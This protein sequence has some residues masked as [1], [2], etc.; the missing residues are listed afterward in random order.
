MKKFHYVLLQNSALAYNLYKKL[1][2]I[3]VTMAP[4][5]RDA[6]HCCGIAILYKNEED[7]EK[8]EEIAKKEGI[9]ID[10]FFTKDDDSDV[11]RNRFL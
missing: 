8:I 4:T 3:E 6:D 11:N 9:K 1:E 10:A 5:P 2:N 7:R